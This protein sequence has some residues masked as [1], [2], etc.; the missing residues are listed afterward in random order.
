[1]GDGYGRRVAIRVGFQNAQEN[2][3]VAADF[4]KSPS[5]QTCCCSRCYHRLRHAT[6]Y[7]LSPSCR[8]NSQAS[9][10]RSTS[11]LPRRLWQ[12]PTRSRGESCWCS[13]AG[14]RMTHMGQI[15]PIHRSIVCAQLPSQPTSAE[16]IRP[17]L[18]NA[19]NRRNLRN[20]KNRRYGRVM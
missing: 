3:L 9:I 17:K 12:V 6:I 13:H 1:M 16:N 18:E 8:I 7:R 11:P 10:D 14:S 2:V 19:Q 5:E 4:F 20:L 15:K